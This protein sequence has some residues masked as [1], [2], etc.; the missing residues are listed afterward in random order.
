MAA[1]VH[2]Q[3]IQDGHWFARAR[4]AGDYGAVDTSEGRRWF[5]RPPNAEPGD[6]D[7]VLNEKHVV[8]E[9]ADGSISVH[10]SILNRVIDSQAIGGNGPISTR[11][12]RPWH[13]H[14]EHGIWREA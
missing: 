5:N 3:R 13:G 12:P 6:P 14:L 10:A 7:C 2:G 9:H 1:L 4:R 8:V 11:G